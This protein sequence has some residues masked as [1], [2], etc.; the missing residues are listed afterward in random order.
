MGGASRK[1]HSL[2]YTEVYT[3]KLC[4][5]EHKYHQSTEI[6]CTWDTQEDTSYR[7]LILHASVNVHVQLLHVLGKVLDEYGPPIQW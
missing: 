4:F 1:Q 7:V 6:D 2:D 3:Q 5:T